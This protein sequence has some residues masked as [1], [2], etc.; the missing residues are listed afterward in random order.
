MPGPLGMVLGKAKAELEI[1][2]AKEIEYNK[3]TIKLLVKVKQ[4]K[5]GTMWVGDLMTADIDRHGD[6]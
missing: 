2:F 4:G 5:C 3:E 6:N 1:R